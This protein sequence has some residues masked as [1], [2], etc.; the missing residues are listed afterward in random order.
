MFKTAL[1]Y[2]SISGTFIIGII[3][4]G[5]KF[6]D[7]HGSGVFSSEWFGYLVMI[8]SLSTIFL[9]IR[10]YRNKKLGGVIKFFPALGLGVMIALIAGIA[11]VAAW[12]IYLYATH[13]AFMDNYVAALSERLRASGE[14]GPALQAKLAELEQMRVSY[15][16]PLFRF[17]MTFIEIFPV[18]LLIALISAGL[19]R[20]PKVL[21]A[22]A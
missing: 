9:A 7:Q 17:G 22:R 4:I 8:V 6:G 12:E 14:T 16:N 21:P 11:Y 20:N 1:I 13:Y 19:L 2:G 10:D 3:L 15:Q 18:G 5:L